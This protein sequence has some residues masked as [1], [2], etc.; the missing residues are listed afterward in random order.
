VNHNP[1][2]TNQRWRWRFTIALLVLGF[3]IFF[4]IRGDSLLSAVAAAFLVFLVTAHITS[5]FVTEDSGT[6]PPALPTSL[7]PGVL[8]VPAV[9]EPSVPG[10]TELDIEP[11]DGAG[12]TRRAA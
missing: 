1:W 5:W 11:D 9:S 6:R 10:V 2:L 4:L 3:V 7:L 12:E 8:G